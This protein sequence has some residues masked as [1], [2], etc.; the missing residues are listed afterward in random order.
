MG[1]FRL[2]MPSIRVVLISAVVLA[3]GTLASGQD[4]AGLPPAHVSF[5]EGT[6]MVAHDGEWE[7]AVINLP[8]VEGDRV[9]TTAGRAQL[10]FPDGTAIDIDPYSEIEFVTAAQV[11]VSAGS[12]ER[13]A[14]GG[15]D[16]AAAAYLPAPQACARRCNARDT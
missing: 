13:Q 5:V 2:L 3:C 14:A 4:A 15:V 6:A 16:A 8:L 9:R 1:S 10:L 7:A 11:R 12:I